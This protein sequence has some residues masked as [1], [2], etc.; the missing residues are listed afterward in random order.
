MCL[1]YEYFSLGTL[2]LIYYLKLKDKGE[3]SYIQKH[4]ECWA[5]GQ[6]TRLHWATGIISLADSRKRVCYYGKLITLLEVKDSMEMIV[7]TFF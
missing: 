1:K 2:I 4:F 6:V 3:P 7:P 5:A